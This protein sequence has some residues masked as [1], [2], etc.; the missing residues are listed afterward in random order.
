MS[1]KLEIGGMMNLV[2]GKNFMPL[3]LE[4]IFLHRS[5]MPNAINLQALIDLGI[6]DD[7]LYGPS[8][9]LIETRLSTTNHRSSQSKSSPGVPIYNCLRIRSDGEMTCTGVSKEPKTLLSDRTLPFVYMLSA[10]FRQAKKNEPTVAEE[11]PFRPDET[12]ELRNARLMTTVTVKSVRMF[13]LE[14]VDT[15]AL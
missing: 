14:R 12:E 5:S 2:F 7:P 1:D 6:L 11:V 15:S 9:Y 10:A 3:A 4:E 13:R 8:C